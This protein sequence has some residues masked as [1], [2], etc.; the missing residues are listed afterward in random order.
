MMHRMITNRGGS[1]SFAI[2]TMPLGLPAFLPLTN[3]DRGAGADLRLDGD[4]VGRK[5]SKRRATARPATPPATV[6]QSAASI[7]QGERFRYWQGASGRRYLFS[8]VEV[9]ELATFDHAVAILMGST[10]ADVR[11]RVGVIADDGGFQGTA[12]HGMAGHLA[13]EGVEYAYVHLLARDAEARAAV[14]D[15]ISA[16]L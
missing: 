13:L 9:D 1:T 16:A 10:G 12:G 8:R 4:S 6:P 7:G 5:R 15:D 14:V 3:Q 11:A 2:T